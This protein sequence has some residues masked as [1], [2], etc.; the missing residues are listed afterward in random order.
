MLKPCILT[1]AAFTCRQVRY[2][3]A[4][5]VLYAKGFMQDYFA[6][7]LGSYWDFFKFEDSTGSSSSAS[8][9]A[10]SSMRPVTSNRNFRADDNSVYGAGW[11]FDQQA[12]I[13]RWGA[14]LHDACQSI[15]CHN[16]RGRIS[17]QA[18]CIHSCF[19]TVTLLTLFFFQFHSCS[20]SLSSAVDVGL[21]QSDRLCCLSMGCTHYMQK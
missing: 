12:Y 17:M 8:T 3:K 1:T 5:F 11:S 13:S 16:L 19:S 6:R 18:K 20:S 2:L 14:V 9:L 21:C 4:L 15:C 10:R 7:L